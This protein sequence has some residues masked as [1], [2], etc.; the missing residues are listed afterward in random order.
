MP[1][2]RDVVLLYYRL[3][4]R[5]RPKKLAGAFPSEWE[6]RRW[7]KARPR[8]YTPA[9]DGGEWLWIEITSGTWASVGRVKQRDHTERL[10]DRS[11]AIAIKR[12]P[13]TSVD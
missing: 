2:A 8:R 12:I 1:E 9:K 7:L 11:T 6:A 4:S 3:A 5:G 13:M 10:I